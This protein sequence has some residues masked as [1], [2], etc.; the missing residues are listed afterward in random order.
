MRGVILADKKWPP[1]I[2]QYLGYIQATENSGWYSLDGEFAA[3]E[4][5]YGVLCDSSVELVKWE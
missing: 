1:A 5:E 3:F 2:P 4:K